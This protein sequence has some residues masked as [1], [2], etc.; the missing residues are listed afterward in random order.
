M[1]MRSRH[2][3]YQP[4]YPAYQGY[5]SVDKPDVVLALF[6]AQVRSK[7]AD[8]GSIAT[9]ITQLLIEGPEGGGPLHVDKSRF[10]DAQGA[11]NLI[12]MP[13]WA[14]KEDQAAFWR[15]ADVIAFVE[16]EISGDAGWWVE[17]FYARTTSLDAS[18]AIR[19][20]RYGIGRHS[21]IQVQQYHAYMGSM[22]DRVPDYLQGK[23]DAEARQLQRLP[24]LSRSLG[25]TIRLSELPDKLCFIRGGFAWKDALPEEQAAY[26]RD[27]LPVYEEGANYLRD[28]PIAS[29]CISMRM[30]EELN[31]A[32][33]TGVQSNAIG[34]FLS[35]NDLERWV[36]FHPRHLAIMKTIMDYMARFNFKPKLNL[37]H[38]VIVV[39]GGQ[40]TC[41]YANC[42]DQTGFLPYFR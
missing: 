2:S 16:E 35:L 5:Q 7:D 11:E 31:E 20:V 34:W 32:F 1:R 36:R 18:Y 12:F 28:N 21:D 22:R 4:P 39:P 38:E 37:G 42:H 3:D 23:A 15:R 24:T 26:M 17:S 29:N 40:L 25:R 9:A 8:D 27:M 14:T 19:D 33:D 30:T 6:A 13:Y 41:I 10:V